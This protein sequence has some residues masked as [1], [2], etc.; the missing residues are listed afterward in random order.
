MAVVDTATVVAIAANQLQ[1]M[2]SFTRGLR[3]DGCNH[4]SSVHNIT[5][6]GLGYDICC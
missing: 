2:M 4:I 3:L 1:P 5:A 6:P